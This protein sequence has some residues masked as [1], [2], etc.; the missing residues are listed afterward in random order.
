MRRCPNL[1]CPFRVQH[2]FAAEFRG[3]IER[4][5]SCGGPLEL[6]TDNSES[7]VSLGALPWAE[8]AGTTLVVAALIALARTPAPG[9]S[10]LDLGALALRPTI[11]ALILAAALIELALRLVPR[12]RARAESKTTR[13]RALALSWGLSLVL[14]VAWTLLGRG[15]ALD[16]GAALTLLTAATGPALLLAGAALID[17]RGLGHGTSLVIAAVLVDGLAD[18]ISVARDPQQTSALI[19]VVFIGALVWLGQPARARALGRRAHEGGTHEGSLGLGLDIPSTSLLP[20]W[21]A[22]ALAIFIVEPND[23]AAAELTA[24]P[25]FTALIHQAPTATS[26]T[27]LSL[28]PSTDVLLLLAALALLGAAG[29]WLF[30]RPSLLLARWQRAFPRAAPAELEREAAALSRR[31]L[32]RSELLLLALALAP[33]PLPMVLASVTLAAILLDLGAELR[34]RIEHPS[35]EREP[36]E[37]A[38]LLGARSQA[39][40]LELAHTPA[41]VQAAH[42]RALW[43]GLGWWLPLRVFRSAAKES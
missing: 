19:G 43:L 24:L 31:A 29:A 17:R 10:A 25:A 2:G 21:I 39:I 14:T 34:F 42:H 5:R 13:E 1:A 6:A 12:L 40:A 4:C 26:A 18:A 7:T 37:D 11:P 33:L 16:H 28:A 8:L 38:S 35:L 27:E 41:F 3:D 32:I 15:G 20:L 22:A 9:A 36:L 30:T 23:T